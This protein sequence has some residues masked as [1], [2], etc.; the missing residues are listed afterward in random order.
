[1]EHYNTAPARNLLARDQNDWLELFQGVHTDHS[2]LF[3]TADTV[4]ARKRSEQQ[5]ILL[6]RRFLEFS[7]GEVDYQRYRVDPVYTTRQ[8]ASLCA[9]F[10]GVPNSRCFGRFDPQKMQDAL[11]KSKLFIQTSSPVIPDVFMWSLHMMAVVPIGFP[12]INLV[13]SYQS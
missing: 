9:S 6:L 11:S 3:M 2:E 7:G 4:R 8:N 12:D 13:H 10:L 1:M 5:T